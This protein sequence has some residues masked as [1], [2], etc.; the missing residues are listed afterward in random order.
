MNDD[1][2]NK[3]LKTASGSSSEGAGD[4]RTDALEYENHTLR[5][6]V[7]QLRTENALLRQQ[8]Q[9]LQGSHEALPVS[10]PTVVDLSRIDTDIILE[11]A[12]FVG[13]SRDLLNLALT[14]RSFGWQ[15]PG[16]AS[17]LS[18]AEDVAQQAV[19]SKQNVI[20]GVR[21]TLLHA[22]CVRGRKTWLSVLHESEIPLKFDTLLGRGIEH[23]NGMRTSVR[24]TCDDIA[25]AVA[26]NYVMISG[27]HYANFSVTCEE[28]YIGIV[29][30]MPNL[31]PARFA[32]VEFHFSLVSFYDDFMAEK[33]GEWGDGNVHVCEYY[34]ENGGAIWTDWD[35]EEEQT[36]LID[37]EG[38]EGC[39]TGDTVGML[40]NL[41]EG[42]LTV[43]K[44]NRRLGVMKDGL[45][46]SYCWYTTV[47]FKHETVAIRRGEPPRA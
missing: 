29:R 10:S 1:Q 27:T 7:T 19:R 23:Q 37:W 4:V 38:M 40:L 9:R 6:E 26:S 21:I 45:S 39:R 44:N 17:N 41:D 13:T 31:D 5:S 30:P 33:T 3:R 46:G 47:S 18:L 25:T 2:G 43:Y 36:P 8:V 32:D 15:Q 11:I 14:S 24:A 12:S 35:Q 16:V 22:Q 34:S 20:E 42:T 28:S